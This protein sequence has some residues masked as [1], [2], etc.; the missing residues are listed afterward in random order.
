[1]SKYVVTGDCDNA[2]RQLD[3]LFYQR[4]EPISILAVLSSTY[5]DMYRVRAVIESGGKAQDAAGIYDYKRKEFRLNQAERYAKKLPTQALRDSLSV[6]AET[7]EL[8]K[9]TP[10]DN[11]L[12]LQ[13]LIAKLLMISKRSIPVIK[14]K[15]AVVVEGKYDKMRLSALIDAPIIETNGFRVFRDKEKVSLIKS[16]RRRGGCSF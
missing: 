3:Q 9:S 4:E 16:W 13:E 14:I 15:Q 5:V 7:D 10:R 12:L 8:M 11:A 1:M 6:L 2:Y